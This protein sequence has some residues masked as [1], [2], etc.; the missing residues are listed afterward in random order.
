MSYF[1]RSGVIQAVRDA[2]FSLAPGQRLGL[3]GESGSGKTTAALAIMGLLR[4]PGRVIAGRIV[5]DGEDLV[6][7]DPTALARLRLA[8]ISYVPQGAMNSLNPVLRIGTSIAHALAAHGEMLSGAALRVRLTDLLAQVGLSADVA[9][10]FPHELSGGMKQRVC[11]AIAISLGPSVIIAD[12]PTSALD[13]VT[14]R[15]VMRTLRTAQD[16]LGSALVLIGHD[17]G[18]MAQSVDTIAV[19]R[20][21][22]IVELA[23]AGR[24]FRRPAH[25]Y[26]EKLIRSVP[27]IGGDVARRTAPVAAGHDV[28]LIELADVTKTFPHRFGE[29]PVTALHKLSFALPANDPRIVAVVGQSGSGK[30]TLGSLVL[31]FTAPSEGT[32]KWR[33]SDLAALP[34]AVRKVFRREVQA[35]FQDPYSTFNP[36]YRVAR[37]LT[38]PLRS[39]GLAGSKQEARTLADAACRQV[40]LNP[41]ALLDRFPHQL[42]G[43]QRQ[44]LMIA[45]ALLLRPR[46][47]VADEPV[48]MVDASLR[49][50][51]LDLLVELRDKHGIAIIYITHDL[52]TA[53]RVSDEVMVL[54]R[55]RVVE[56]GAPEAVLG[57]PEHPY[58]KLL[59]DCLPWPDPERPWGT[60]EEETSLRR[61]IAEQEGAPAIIREDLPA[62]EASRP[63]VGY[64]AL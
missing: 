1:T 57:N 58:T 52:A 50:D 32:I 15:Q 30:T 7:Q 11:I 23:E 22:E 34:G 3:A 18:L 39:F 38:L 5:L 40:G 42:S 13:V 10:R 6:G 19:M 64:G 12:E 43:G 56:S 55:G 60:P 53:Y 24:M 62:S 48:S 35:V 27:V 26:T 14:Q 8:R 17:M 4:A 21:G 9:D 49:A 28:P 61:E 2:S 37:S 51:I 44:R 54:H 29:A 16:R 31:G 33:G 59:V 25:A 36:F 20:A 63:P 41:D 45:R 46:L 47:L